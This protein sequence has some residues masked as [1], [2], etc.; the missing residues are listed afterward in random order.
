ME[1]CNENLK[2]IYFKKE[3]KMPGKTVG[4]SMY[5]MIINLRKRADTQSSDDGEQ[6][7]E[8]KVR[9]PCLT[10]KIISNNVSVGE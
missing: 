7:C 5:Q 8:A 1:S 6:S 2:I 9:I 3:L 4:Y 10:R